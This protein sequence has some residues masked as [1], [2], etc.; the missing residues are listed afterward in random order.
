MVGGVPPAVVPR[1]VRLLAEAPKPNHRRT[2]S[3]ASVLAERVSTRRMAR[4]AVCAASDA[5]ARRCL[6]ALLGAYAHVPTID[7]RLAETAERA[8]AERLRHAD[9]RV[10]LDAANDRLALDA[11]ERGDWED[12]RRSAFPSN[13]PREEDESASFVASSSAGS[14]RDIYIWFAARAGGEEAMAD[15]RYAAR[16]RSP[17]PRQVGNSPWPQLRANAGCDQATLRLS[18]RCR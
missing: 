13:N 16:R 18:D 11:F 17:A 7:A 4:R 2:V 12:L 3:I 9:E 8:F 14:S 15:D 10:A 5:S 6:G 1:L